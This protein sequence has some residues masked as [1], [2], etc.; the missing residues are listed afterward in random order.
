MNVIVV[1]ALVIALNVIIGCKLNASTE[2]V[3]GTSNLTNESRSI[4]IAGKEL[5]QDI[6]IKTHENRDGIDFDIV[7]YSVSSFG[8][9]QIDMRVVNNSDSV[10]HRVNCNIWAFQDGVEKDSIGI[11]FA[12]S[13]P[14]EPGESNASWARFGQLEDNFSDINQIRIECGWEP[15]DNDRKDVVKGLVRVDFVRYGVDD[16]TI[17]LR[18]TNNLANSISHAICKVKGMRGK[19]IVHTATVYFGNRDLITP[20]EAVDGAS[21]FYRM[22]SWDEIDS[23]NFSPANLYCIYI[24]RG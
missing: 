7:G 20:G 22:E 10:V 3:E 5:V 12:H 2:V 6:T 17:H 13:T 18:L 23:D 24:V 19:V 8:H 4:P 21:W 11:D 16:R 14:I 1:L 15:G 9:G